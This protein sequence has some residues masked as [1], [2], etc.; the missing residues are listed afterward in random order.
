MTQG[1][2]GKGRW[3]RRGR[4]GEDDDDETP[5]NSK[6]RLPRLSRPMICANKFNMRNYLEAMR[7]KTC[8][9]QTK[10]C[11]NEQGI[12]RTPKQLLPRWRGRRSATSTYTIKAQ[13]SKNEEWSWGRCKDDL[14]SRRQSRR[15]QPSPKTD[16]TTIFSK[17]WATSMATS[18]AW[19][20]LLGFVWTDP[21]GG[22]RSQPLRRHQQLLRQQKGEWC[23]P[24]RRASHTRLRQV[25]VPKLAPCHEQRLVSQAAAADEK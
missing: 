7:G 18:W 8:Q 19:T 23:L 1:C 4:G 21:E 22:R 20:V 5:S 13:G 14:V 15:K 24:R 11:K 10:E 3:R 9:T 17:C 12:C 2:F 6:R 25:R 16:F